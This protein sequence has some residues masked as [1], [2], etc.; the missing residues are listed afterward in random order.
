MYLLF[1]L[2]DYREIV[3]EFIPWKKFGHTSFENFILSIPDVVRV[4]R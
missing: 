2:E 4:E 1:V 3:G